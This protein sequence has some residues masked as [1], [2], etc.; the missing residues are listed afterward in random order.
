MSRVISVDGPGK[1][2]NQH[3]RTIAEALR[4]LSQKPQFDDEVR[5]LAA[6]IVFCLHGIADTIDRTTEAW[7]KRDYYLK[8]DRFREE[9]RWLDPMA[10]ELSGVIYE[11]RWDELPLA[12]TQLM[13]H[14]ADIKI[15]KMTRNP[16]L[17]Q[18]AYEK[19]LEGD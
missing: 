16:S 12:L 13:P 10:D 15:K 11:G 17:W 9:W 8:A 5:D 14:F 3:R 6:I 2:R 7:E 4:R 19:L 18:G 1:V